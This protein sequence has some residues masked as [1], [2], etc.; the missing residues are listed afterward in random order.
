MALDE[1]FKTFVIHVIS[2]NLALGIHLDRAAQIAPLLTK[3]VK[4]LDDYSDFADV[5]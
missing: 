4:I 2:F 5:F 3:K 1:N